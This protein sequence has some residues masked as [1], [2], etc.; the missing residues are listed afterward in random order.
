MSYSRTAV[1]ILALVLAACAQEPSRYREVLTVRAGES[2][3]PPGSAPAV[4]WRLDEND[5]KTLSPTP[6]AP[7][8]PP[9]RV[10]PPPRPNAEYPHGY[11]APPVYWQQRW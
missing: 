7:A 10:P 4:T 6:I 11:Y 1:L 3:P 9:P 5:L 2:A 8:P